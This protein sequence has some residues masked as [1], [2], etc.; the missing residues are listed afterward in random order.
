MIGLRKEALHSCPELTNLFI[1]PIGLRDQTESMCTRCM[2]RRK[3]RSYSPS[4]GWP[5]ISSHSP[6]T[7][8]Q[9]S[10][11]VKKSFDASL[12]MECDVCINRKNV[13]LLQDRRML[14][15]S[16][17]GNRAKWW[18]DTSGVADD[19]S[20]RT[21]HAKGMRNTPSHVDCTL[22]MLSSIGRFQLSKA[23]AC[24]LLCDDTGRRSR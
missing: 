4:L 20:G 18:K 14:S 6:S 19:F 13:G 21:W 8:Y 16:S 24:M 5:P 9:A 12:R 2:R 15:C 3:L 1:C 17:V 22:K 10:G 11:S 23:I 7:L